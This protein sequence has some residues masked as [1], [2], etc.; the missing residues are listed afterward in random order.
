MSYIPFL[1]QVFL[2]KYDIF[3]Y[4]ITQY[5]Y[6]YIFLKKYTVKKL[7]INN[8][9]TVYFFSNF[10]TIT[11]TFLRYIFQQG[12]TFFMAHFLKGHF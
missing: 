4:I 11:M 10:V 5:F 7:F 3:F 9:F 1:Q 8:F 6:F 2:I 12:I